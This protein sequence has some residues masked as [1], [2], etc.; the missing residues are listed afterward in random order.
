MGKQFVICCLLVFFSN[1]K[2]FSQKFSMYFLPFS[3]TVNAQITLEN[4]VLSNVDG[5]VNMMKYKVFQ[6]LQFF[7]LRR[8][9]VIGDSLPKCGYSH[10]F[11]RICHS[12]IV[13]KWY[14]L[15][16]SLVFTLF[17]IWTFIY[18]FTFLAPYNFLRAISKRFYQSLHS[19]CKLNDLLNYLK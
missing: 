18:I 17:T 13:R 4:H 2:L 15:L 6:R 19:L 11:F 14:V 5:L 3:R 10:A 8:R 1:K 12:I 7:A 9:A 16:Y